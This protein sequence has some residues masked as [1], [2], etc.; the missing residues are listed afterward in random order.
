MLDDGAYHYMQMLQQP[1][2]RRTTA[3]QLA[4]IDYVAFARAMGLAYIRIGTNDQV[5]GSLHSA[6]TYPGPILIHVCISYKGRELRWLSALRASY[7]D[8]LDTPEKLRLGTKVAV[9]SVKPF[10][11]ND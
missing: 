4:P 6:L 8:K 1:L 2:Y 11:V 9:R 7:L 10:K 3:T 5:P